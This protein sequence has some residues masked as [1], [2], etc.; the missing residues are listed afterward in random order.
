LLL[1]CLLKLDFTAVKVRFHSSRT[2]CRN[3]N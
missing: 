1:W 3:C 2:W